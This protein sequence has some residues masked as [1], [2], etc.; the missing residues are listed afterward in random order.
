MANDLEKA[1][2]AQEND[3][4]VDDIP[5]RLTENEYV[6]PADAVLILGQGDPQAGAAALDQFV[7]YIRKNKPQESVNPAPNVV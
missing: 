6:I 7:E 1:L 5:A 2:Q 3:I 4:P